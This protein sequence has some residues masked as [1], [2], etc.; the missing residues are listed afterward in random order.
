[1]INHIRTL[2]RNKAGHLPGTPG[3]EYVSPLFAPVRLP[4]HLEVIRRCLVGTGDDEIALNYRLRLCMAILNSTGVSQYLDALD[5]RTSYRSN[6]TSLLDMSKSV[7]VE[8][9]YG[10]AAADLFVIGNFQTASNAA[11]SKLRWR[12]TVD[13]DDE[14]TVIRLSSPSESSTQT[15]TEQSAGISTPVT[16]P[17]SDLSVQIGILAA[18]AHVNS[19]WELSLQTVPAVDLS[20]IYNS[21]RNVSTAEL[22]QGGMNSPYDVFYQ[23]WQNNKQLPYALSGL[24]CAYV[25]RVDELIKSGTAS[26]VKPIPAVEPLPIITTPGPQTTNE[27]VVKVING[28]SIADEDNNPQTVT[29]SVTAGS[30]TLVTRTGLTFTVGS[31]ITDTSTQFS[32]SLADVNAAL[33]VIVYFPAANAHTV[34][35]FSIAT[36]DGTGGTDSDS[37]TITIASVND[38]PVLDKPGTQTTSMNTAKAISGII[39]YDT[40]ND[41]QTVTISVTNGTLTLASTAGLTFSVGDGTADTTMTFSGTR[42][43][44]NAALAPVTYNPTN[45]FTGSATLS[46]SSSDGQGGTDSETVLINVT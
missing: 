40:D 4:Q 16:L 9:I 8:K 22:F 5:S 29:L 13:S 46:V 45:A 14:I 34:E 37:F 17:G 41:P 42:V 28:L 20:S 25:Q 7:L 39:I 3:D 43:A 23:M 24:I 12:V 33:G 27:D 44:C 15:Y 36:N 19:S 21:L 38:E 18:D 11:I 6:D 31:G 2:L 26:F 35:T 30:Y 1:M 32:G 10:D